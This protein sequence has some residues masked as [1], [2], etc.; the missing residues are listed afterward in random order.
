MADWWTHYLEGKIIK[1]DDTPQSIVF[2]I[3][4]WFDGPKSAMRRFVRGEP[5]SARALMR[6]IDKCFSTNTF[7]EEI[8]R[9][10]ELQVWVNREAELARTAKELR[11]AREAFDAAVEGVGLDQYYASRI[12]TDL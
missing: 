2:T 10:K 12:A 3:E 11:D 9:L 8:P 6:E 7:D 5:V 1:R 4:D